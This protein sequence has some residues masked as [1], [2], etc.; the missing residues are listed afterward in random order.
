MAEREKEKY[1]QLIQGRLNLLIHNYTLSL[2]KK[3]IM[4]SSR[5]RYVHGLGTGGERRVVKTC[6]IGFKDKYEEV[7]ISLVLPLF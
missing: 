7:Q 2:E 3:D 6:V 4:N 1:N 5:K